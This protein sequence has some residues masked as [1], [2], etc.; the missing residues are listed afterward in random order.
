MPQWFE[1]R[2]W[3][4][5]LRTTVFIAVV[6]LIPL[7]L[8]AFVDTRSPASRFAL[9]VA[10]VLV[11]IASGGVY[12]AFIFESEIAGRRRAEGA[13][14]ESQTLL[15]A[16]SDHSRA[17]IYVKDLSGRYLMVNR[18]FSELFHVSSEAVTGKTDYDLFSREAA[19]A[20]RAMDERVAAAGVPITEEEVAPQDDGLHTYV[21]V[22]APLLDESGTPYAVFGV[23]TDVTDRKRAE[24]ALRASEERTRLIVEAALDAVVTIDGAGVVTGWNP[25]AEA[26]FGWAPPEVVGR[27]LADVIIPEQYRDQHRRGLAR[28]LETGEGPVL[29]KRIEITA[30]HR[31]GREIPIELSITPLHGNGVVAFGAFVRDI[32]DRRRAEDALRES[33]VRYR[34]LAEALPL[35]VWTCTPDGACDYLS[36]QWVAYTGRPA[37]EQLGYGW[38]EYLHPDD[39]ARVEA[40]WAAATARGDTF[41]LEF[42]IRRADGVYR[43]F[44]T[45]AVPS[46]DG[47]GRIAKWFG[48]NTDIE[49]HKRAER[50]L[51]AQLERLSLLDHITRAIGERQDLHSVFEA[52]V[53]SLEDDL[54]ID[55]GCVCLH[56][57][58]T[59]ML[60]VAAVGAR[61]ATLAGELGLSEHARLPLDRNGLSQC[62]RGQLVYEPDVSAVAFPFA[63]RLAAGGL[64]S[65]VAAP[66][67]VESKVMGVLLAARVEVQSFGSAD[68]EFLRQLGEHVGLAANQAQ[69]YGALQTA[70][71]DLRQSQQSALQLERLRAL[72]QMASGIAHDINNAISPVVLYTEALLVDEEGLSTRAREYLETIQRAVDDVAQTVARLGEFYRNREPQ[73]TLTPVD[74]NLLVQQVV[75]LTRARWSDMA[76]Q[77]GVVIAMSADLAASLPVVMGSESEIREALTN[78]VFNAVDAMPEGGALTLRTRP[79]ELVAG[80]RSVAGRDVYLEVSDTGIGMDEET[81]R[82]CLEPFFTTKGERG[83]GLGLAMVYGVVQRHN[84]DVEIE[85]RLGAGTT[86]RLRFDVSADDR[87]ASGRAGGAPRPLVSRRILVVDDDPLLLRSLHDALTSDGHLVTTANG[88]QAGIET[89]RAA[90]SGSERFEAVITDLGMPYVDGRKV[91]SAVKAASP[92]TPVLLLTGWG[93]RLMADGDVPASVDRVLSKPPKMR[94]LRAALAECLTEPAAGIADPEARAE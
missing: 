14:R 64:R 38:A 52:V 22:K 75:N 57:A 56:D 50:R 9:L 29:N 60:T 42:R 40:A 54:T 12:T 16:I 20:F 46:R 5:R 45:R 19:D 48:S 65:L 79:G 47:A 39:G 90:R 31:D 71:D 87:A 61:S 51:R 49:D 11:A 33:E 67:V 25:Q 32:T 43:W 1:V 36:R 8:A 58:D 15:Q 80:S 82:R 92:T 84:A 27:S 74:L 34:T 86:V 18:R 70:Y 35:L 2:E 10:V 69:L 63:R 37:E 72:G 6:S 21:S 44:K 77:R 13:V 41:D 3:P 4:L 85:S 66:L 94:E 28:Y 81:R 55:F 17:V 26:T 88:G 78:L 91:A 62:L 76:Q 30:L 59:D 73:L 89:F 83:T 53:R 68:C 24:A 7:A 23:S 93:Q